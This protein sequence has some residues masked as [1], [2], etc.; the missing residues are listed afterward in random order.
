MR[1]AGCVASG[2]SR[3]TVPSAFATNDDLVILYDARSVRLGVLCMRVSKPQ[4]CRWGA[5]LHIGSRYLSFDILE[6]EERMTSKEMHHHVNRVQEFV[7]SDDRHQLAAPFFVSRSGVFSGQSGVSL[8]N[9]PGNRETGILRPL[10]GHRIAHA[11]KMLTKHP[12]ASSCTRPSVLA[13]HSLSSSYPL[14]RS[15]LPSGL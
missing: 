13:P 3:C 8:A 2:G 15:P 11:Q 7:P 12:L 10:Q 5:G 9:S 14:T 4:P 1:V 6:D